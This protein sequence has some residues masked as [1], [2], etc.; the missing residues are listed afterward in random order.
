MS[1]CKPILPSR[2]SQSRKMRVICIGLP[3]ERRR[4]LH[5]IQPKRINLPPLTGT[6]GIMDGL[7]RLL[8]LAVDCKH[9]YPPDQTLQ[10]HGPNGVR[11][12]SV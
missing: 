11:I 5:G 3:R 6:L 12:V 2:K 8:P 9:S 4:N 1:L 7:A 10:L